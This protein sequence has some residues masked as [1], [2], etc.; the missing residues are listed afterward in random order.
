MDARAIRRRTLSVAISFGI[1]DYSVRVGRAGRG[2]KAWAHCDYVRKEF[3]FTPELLLCDWVFVNQ[4]ILHEVAHAVAGPKAGHGRA[5]RDTARAMGYRLGAKVPYDN[6]QA[7]PHKWAVVCQTGAHS[8]IKHEKTYEDWTR[9]CE[10]CWEAGA[11]EVFV[12]WEEL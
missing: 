2:V 10:P 6:P 5:W 9:L 7:I 8:A 1:Q 12:Y 11:G 3:V 4:I